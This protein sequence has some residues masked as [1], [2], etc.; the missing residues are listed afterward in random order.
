MPT[1]SSLSPGP[2]RSSTSWSRN[3]SSSARV[4]PTARDPAWS[5]T[6]RL[7]GRLLLEGE[8]ARRADRLAGLRLEREPH[9][10]LDLA[11]AL[12]DLLGGLVEPELKADLAR[13]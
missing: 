8:G 12:D 4:N 3:A 10:D 11:L 1:N 9:A 6:A 5:A 2:T 7:P 13:L